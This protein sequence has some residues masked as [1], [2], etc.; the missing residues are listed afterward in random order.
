MKRLLLPTLSVFVF[1]SLSYAGYQSWR[2]AQARAESAPLSAVHDEAPA[3]LADAPN[4]PPPLRRRHA[5]RV[6]L[7]IEILEHQKTL[8]D[9]VS[10]TYWTFGDDAPGKFIRVRQGDVVE[11]HVSNHPDNSLA[12]NVDFHAVTGP[13]GGG[14]VTFVAPGHSATFTWRALHAGLY[15]YHCVAAPA[16]LHIANGMFG[17]ILVEPPEGLPPVDHEFFLVQ[18]EFY[19]TGD[20]GEPGQQ[21]F[22]MKKALEERPEYVVFNGHVGALM[23]DRSLK[24]RTGE[25]V[26]LYLGNAGPSLVSS[27]HVVGEIFDR[28]YGEGGLDVTQREVQT[29]LIP[30]G[31]SAIVEFVAD[32]PGDYQMV[33]HSMFRAFNKGAMGMLQIAGPGRE[34]LF[35]APVVPAVYTPE[36]R[37][38]RELT[39]ITAAADSATAAQSGA[40]IYATIC[41]TC[42]QQDGR[43]LPGL[44]PPLAQ[45][46]F[47]M[48]DK[49]RSVQVLLHGLTGKI[50]V[51]G[52][53]FDGVM[54]Q[55]R[56]SDAQIAAVLSHVRSRFGNDA[57]PVTLADVERVRSQS[58][59]AQSRSLA[60]TRT[61][62]KNPW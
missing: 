19:T 4:V 1:L 27:F 47:L 26:R 48:A 45:S 49:D 60:A 7:D 39:V 44:F 51:N 62:Q 23:G 11:T 43:G 56:L 55:L 10:Y 42:H 58:T 54:P 52:K 9:G 13:G 15:L 2:F 6:R 35:S 3:A 16:G 57:D 24:V 36:A 8:A 38:D 31:G 14:D 32:V 25:S 61:A 37:T 12:H 34:D 28:V 21:G 18:S 22:S 29:T 20:Y 5:A 50:V 33:D 46:D 41:A 59:R 53:P 17:L 40:H 30:V